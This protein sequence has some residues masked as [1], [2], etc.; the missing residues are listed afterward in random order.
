[1]G[2]GAKEMLRRARRPH[3][4]MSGRSARSAIPTVATP[5]TTLHLTRQRAGDRT[6]GSPQI[7]APPD[8]ARESTPRPSPPRGQLAR[9]ASRRR[10]PEDRTAGCGSCTHR[11]NTTWTRARVASSIAAIIGAST[12]DTSWSTSGPDAAD[13]RNPSSRVRSL[14]TSRTTS[15]CRSTIAACRRSKTGRLHN[16]EASAVISSCAIAGCRRRASRT[17]PR[18]APTEVP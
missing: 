18:T 6:R 9:G 11:V 8:G 16:S 2:R 14:A 1:M 12:S 4:R 3:P 10:W 15:V 7:E 13:R 17:V 5:R